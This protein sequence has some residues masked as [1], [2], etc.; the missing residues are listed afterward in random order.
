MKTVQDGAA[1]GEGAAAQENI[2]VVMGEK[3]RSQLQRD[4]RS[5]IFATIAGALWP[6]AQVAGV[7]AAEGRRRCWVWCRQCPAM[8]G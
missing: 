3:G 5:S 8:S 2:L 6:A 7:L 1:G 4:M